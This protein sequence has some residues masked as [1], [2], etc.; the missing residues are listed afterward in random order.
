MDFIQGIGLLAKIIVMLENNVIPPRLS[1][2]QPIYESLKC[3]AEHAP[4][5]PSIL[6]RAIEKSAD[7]ERALHKV[8]ELIFSDNEIKS[9]VGTT[10]AVD[11]IQ[12][13]VKSNALPEQ[14]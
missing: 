5:V 7:S 11:V 2:S 6:K 1:R 8:E 3:V 14:R 10:Q 9:I 13:G 12:G 4:N